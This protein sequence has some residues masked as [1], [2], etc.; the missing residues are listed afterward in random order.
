MGQKK[1]MW[2]V[3]NKSSILKQFINPII[4]RLGKIGQ[5]II[6]YSYGKFVLVEKVKKG[7]YFFL[8]H[9]S[10][11]HIHICEGPQVVITE[12]QLEWAVLKKKNTIENVNQAIDIFHS[13]FKDEDQ[14]IETKGLHQQLIDCEKLDRIVENKH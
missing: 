12:G 11:N 6:W 13:S 2:I 10:D 3:H 7:E 5:V 9:M 8:R 4:F 14:L 1:M